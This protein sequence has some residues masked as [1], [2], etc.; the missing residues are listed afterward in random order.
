MCESCKKAWFT[1]CH[2]IYKNM[3]IRDLKWRISPSFCEH[4]FFLLVRALRG[5]SWLCIFHGLCIFPLPYSRPGTHFN[6][7][8]LPAPASVAPQQEIFS[9]LHPCLPSYGHSKPGA[10][11]TE[12]QLCLGV[13]SVP[14][15]REAQAGA[16]PMAGMRD[17]PWQLSPAQC[18][19][20]H[21]LLPLPRAQ[22][23]CLPPWRCPCKW[24]SPWNTW[25]P[26]PVSSLGLSMVLLTSA[27]WV[28]SLHG[29]LS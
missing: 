25:R 21:V 9:S 2:Y 13:W 11:H 23:A 27:S 24:G 20:D 14:V 26:F 10:P 4:L 6:P 16:A 18:H 5:L 12:W 22:Q 28:K 7:L 3:G 29:P 1:I 15:P 19:G 8:G 17:G